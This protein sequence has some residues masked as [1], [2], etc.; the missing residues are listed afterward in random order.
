MTVSG[1]TQ[2][3]SSEPHGYP[4]YPKHYA[5]HSIHSS[6]RSVVTTLRDTQATQQSG[7]VITDGLANAKGFMPSNGF[8][9]IF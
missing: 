8:H 9:M 1:D 3:V 6:L 5:M 2:K 4:R 7:S